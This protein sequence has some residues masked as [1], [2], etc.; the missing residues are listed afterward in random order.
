M[1]SKCWKKK[2]SYQEH[3]AKLSFRNEEAIELFTEKKLRKEFIF[4]LFTYIFMNG[5]IYNANSFIKKLRYK[6]QHYR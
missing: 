3:L 1:Y 2:T 4:L 5:K 6:L